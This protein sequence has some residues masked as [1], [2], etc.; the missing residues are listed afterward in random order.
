M[1]EKVK[2]NKPDFS[3]DTLINERDEFMDASGRV[4]QLCV[5]HEFDTEQPHEHIQ[6]VVVLEGMSVCRKHAEMLVDLRERDYNPQNIIHDA[7][8]GNL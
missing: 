6:S 7:I 3:Q 5:V 8:Y 4:I 1:S 2:S